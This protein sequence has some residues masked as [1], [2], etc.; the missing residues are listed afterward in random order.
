MATGTAPRR[1]GAGRPWRNPGMGI[2][3]PIQGRSAAML[4][5]P[6]VSAAMPQ[7]PIV[8]LGGFLI[9]AEAYEPLRR[10]LQERT[11]QPALL[12]PATRL[13]WL[14]TSFPSAGCGL[15]DRVAALVAAQAALSPTGRVTLIGHSSGGVML[16]LFLSDQPFEGRRY[17]GKALADT[18]VM[19]GSPHT[20]RRA[21]ALR[22]R[23]ARELPAVPSARRCGTCPWRGISP[24]RRS[25]PPPAASLPPPTER[26][27]AIPAPAAMDWCPWTPPCWPDRSRSPWRGWP[28]AVPSGPAGTG[29]RRWRP[30]GGPWSRAK[31]PPASRAGGAPAGGQDLLHIPPGHPVVG[32]GH[33]QV[34]HQIGRLSGDRGRI[35]VLAGHHELGALLADLLED[36]CCRPPPAACWCSCRPRGARVGFDHPASARC[37]CRPGEGRRRPHRR[38]GAGPRRRSSC[39][40]RCGRP[41]RPLLDR[42]QQHIGVAVVAEARSRWKWPLVAPLCQSSRRERL[43]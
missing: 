32:Q 5:C 31:A 11:G 41:P 13:D 42:E 43:Q 18:L 24:R 25:A 33:L 37:R 4:R 6:P 10:W 40:R 21:T 27:P 38:S 36:R 1:A 22:Q 14:L 8:I 20:A 26:S 15:L 3:P 35:V 29:P 2:I 34:E 19:L 30:A 16:R 7:Q 23:V 9:T 39:G 28:M 12:V 17:N